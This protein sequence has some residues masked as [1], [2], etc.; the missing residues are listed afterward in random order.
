MSFF[1]GPVSSNKS[2]KKKWPCQVCGQEFP[3]R[4]SLQRHLLMHTGWKPYK[5]KYC[6]KGFNR[7]GN[8]KTH[9]ITH[10]A[11]LDNLL[12]LDK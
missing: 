2:G 7:K 4:A 6:G 11:D 12:T 5:C 3:R 8:M 1:V 9:L 10:F